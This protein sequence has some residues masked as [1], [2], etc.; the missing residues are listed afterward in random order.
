MIR[1]VFVEEKIFHRGKNI[2][3][4]IFSPLL[5]LDLVFHNSRELYLIIILVTE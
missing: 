1:N 3:Q 5:I 2:I 4:K